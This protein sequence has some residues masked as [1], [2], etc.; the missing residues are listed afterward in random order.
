ME[1]VV[2][3]PGEGVALVAGEKDR[4]SGQLPGGS[5]GGQE[6]EVTKTGGVGTA[7]IGEGADCVSVRCGLPQQRPG[8][9]LVPVFQDLVQSCLGQGVG[10]GLRSF[11]PAG[12]QGPQAE[13][14]AQDQ[15]RQAA[16]TALGAGDEEIAQPG[17]QQALP[18]PKLGGEDG[19]WDL[20]FRPSFSSSR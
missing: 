5:G 7:V 16:A 1:T 20:H 18:T 11:L 15:K 6:Q 9:P 10:V 19:V 13:N 12:H 17:L 14:E 3:G 4:C 8:L 2:S